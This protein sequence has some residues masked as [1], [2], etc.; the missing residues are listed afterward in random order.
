[1]LKISGILELMTV[2]RGEA[3]FAN[4]MA[5]INVLLLEIT[6]SKANQTYQLLL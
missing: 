5:V 6:V 4:S 3:C 1:M 2:F